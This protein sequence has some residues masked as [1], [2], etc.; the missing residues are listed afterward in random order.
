MMSRTPTPSQPRSRHASAGAVTIRRR[1]ALL[2]AA[3][4]FRGLISTP[5]LQVDE[6][7]ARSSEYYK[8]NNKSTSRHRGKKKRACTASAANS[9][10]TLASLQAK[11]L[12]LEQR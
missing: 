4:A 11:N 7:L 5:D 12:R 9:F 2:L 1:V 6:T 3:E 8:C 10:K